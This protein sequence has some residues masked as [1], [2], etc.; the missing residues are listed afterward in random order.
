MEPFAA[1]GAALAYGHLKESAPDT[2]APVIG[3]DQGVDDEGMHPAVPGHVDEA[4]QAAPFVGA[5]P[6]EA[7]PPDLTPP[8]D[9][10]RCVAEAFGVQGVEL[11]VVEP[12]A[13]PVAPGVS[14]RQQA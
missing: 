5:D 2:A 13:P 6:A 10:E 7:V 11:R 12:G 8:V 4:D 1:G 3:G 14:R 9:G